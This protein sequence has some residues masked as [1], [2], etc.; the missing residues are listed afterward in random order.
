M[1]AS[2]VFRTHRGCQCGKGKQGPGGVSCG[3]KV[4]LGWLPQAKVGWGVRAQMQSQVHTAAVP[5]R[6]TRALS[7]PQWR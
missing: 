1:S 6:Q 5:A 4:R 2:T 7:Q 3:R